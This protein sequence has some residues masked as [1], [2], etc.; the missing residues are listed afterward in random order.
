[1]R[2]A[3]NVVRIRRGGQDQREEAAAMS[4]AEALSF[5]WELS[6][7]VFSLARGCDVESRLQRQVVRVTR[8][9]G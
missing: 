7:E 4:K 1:M 6:R 8:K 3:R 5:V 9:R 2:V